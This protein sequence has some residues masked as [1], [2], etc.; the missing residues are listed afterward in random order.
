MQ[1]LPESV[2]WSAPT[3]ICFLSNFT[4]TFS[5]HLPSLPALHPSCV[6]PC[7]TTPRVSRHAPQPRSCVDHLSVPISLP[8]SVLRIQ[9]VLNISRC[10]VRV[11]W[12]GICSLFA[13]SHHQ[14]LESPNGYF[15]ISTSSSSLYDL[16]M[17]YIKASPRRNR[18]HQTSPTGGQRFGE[19]RREV[20][21]KLS[22][23]FK[24]A[25]GQESSHRGKPG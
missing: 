23:L 2:P 10:L 21:I 1:S 20:N 4:N 13:T 17:I 8:H 3:C 24:K 18:P 12:I 9:Q 7:L 5:C 11:C 16:K 19:G 25:R 14:P 22:S 15:H 6:S